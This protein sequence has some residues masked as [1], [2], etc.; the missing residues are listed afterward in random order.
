MSY[1]QAALIRAFAAVAASTA[2]CFGAYAQPAAADSLDARLDALEAQVTAAEDVSAL[3][4][5]QR[6]YGYYVDKGMWEDVAD[7]YADDAVTNYPAGT[8]IGRESIRKHLFVN[9][10][11]NA[12]GENGLADNRIYN[13]MNIQPVV[14]LEPGG[15]T[16][17]GRWRAF[18]MFG[19]FG[20]GATWAEGA[21]EMT[22]VK[23][24]GVWK[25]KNLDYHSGFAAP[26][27]T[28]WAPPEPQPEGAAAAPRGPRNLPHPADKARSEAC[29]GFPAACPPTM[30]YTNL[31]TTDAGHVWTTVALPSPAGKRVDAERRA[32]DLARR[33]Q[34]LEDEQAIENLQKVYG[35]YL[36]R[37][38]W[39]EVADMFADNGTIEMGLRGVYVGRARVRQFL[40]LLGPAGIKDGEL[41]DHVQLQPVVDVADDGRTAK[42]RS[43]ELNMIGVVD[44]QG[45][46]SEGIYE[47]T[48][49]KENGVWKL[50]D[51]RYFPT[52]ISDYDQGWGKDAQ[53]APTPS[54]ELPPDRPPT[55][56]YA[57]Y[58]KAH[59]PPFHYDN[60]VTGLAPRYPEARGRP[61]AAAVAAIRADVDAGKSARAQRQQTKDVEALVAETERR[62]GR[63]KDF[64]EI[65]NLVSGYG[66]YLDK[67]LWTDLANLFSEGGTIELAQRGVYIGRER[68]RG[69]LFNV[70]G[71]EGP[72]EN[73]LGNHLQ[74]QPVIH[75]ATDG[76]S[77]K[78]RS[79]MMQQLSFGRGAS[80][81]SSI[82]EN[83]FVKE[84]GLWKFSVDHTYNTWGASYAGGW[85]KQTGRGGVPGPSKTYPPD[86]PPSF[87][88]Q[89]FPTVY[90]IPF[91]Y[92]HPVTGKAPSIT[93]IHVFSE[94]AGAPAVSAPSGSGSGPAASSATLGTMP[95]E[96]EAQVRE[97]G[98]R[99][100][101]QKTGEIYAPLQPKEPYE[102]LKVVRDL[103]YGP[104][105]RNVLDVFT[106]PDS[107]PRAAVAR[108]V[109]VFVHG[110]GFARGSKH[111]DGTPFYDN[112]GIWA[113]GH[114]LVGVTINYRLAPESTWP[115]GIEDVGAAVAWLRAN[116]AQ[117]GGDP[118]KIFLWGHSAGAA[119]VGDYIANAALKGRDAGV[120][121][122]ILTS[123][124]YDL[125]KEVSVWKV[126]YGDDVSTYPERSS[127]PGLLKTTVPLLVTDAELDPDMFQEE[128]SKLVAA[129][130]SAGKPVQHVHL[131][132]HSHISET[133]A[134]GT[135][136]RALASPVLEFVRATSAKPGT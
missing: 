100:E 66:Y 123:G 24:N 59:I 70:F 109:V 118:S 124:F 87:T 132:A 53:P 84:D 2:C 135:A 92:A 8:Y 15:Q 21:Y 6:E 62:I 49:V 52:F 82:Y 136:D 14:H 23:Q 81:G 18:A 104:A 39:D 5:L 42:S 91:H 10:G 112:I 111:T 64:H 85:V 78:V 55:S 47:N 83:E 77:A 20:G 74:W 33:A 130:R 45:T 35:Y 73:R 107:A 129:R 69:F 37:R 134:V 98:A 13:H 26:Y 72:Q 110:G 54:T 58:P 108:P 125:G 68:V 96:I 46:W 34:N 7:L 71:K 56:T 40:S 4:R 133:Y 51:L 16:A 43:R 3:K 11:G 114:G 106:A 126:Y 38:M 113:V 31:G 95:P 116:V 128:T 17:K 22:Y 57:I 105:P 28:G 41:F 93:P 90:E 12:L 63:V 25:I 61:S 76:A 97:I 89:M 65:D 79:R 80:L 103:A 9:V 1:R 67:N 117:Y 60:P 86:T 88:F 121:G 27:A 127:L 75:V 44:G 120:A 50:K 101:A 119:H 94:R 29:G 48:W 32:A 102:W 99:I 131:K 115:S 122:S 36:D 19:S 30:H